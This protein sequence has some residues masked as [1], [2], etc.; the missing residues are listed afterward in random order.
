M[1]NIVDN[2]L[3]FLFVYDKVIAEGDKVLK[4]SIDFGAILLYK[5]NRVWTYLFVAA[6]DVYEALPLGSFI[7]VGDIWVAF[8]NMR[9]L[10]IEI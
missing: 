5:L 10:L 2:C 8:C 9:L 1:L 6:L 4:V 7:S 3:I